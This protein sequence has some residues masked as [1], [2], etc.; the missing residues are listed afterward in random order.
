VFSFHYLND[1]P[2]ISAQDHPDLE[3]NVNG[4][5]LIAAPGWLANPPG[6]YLSL[7]TRVG[8]SGSRRATISPGHG[9]S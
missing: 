3:G 2:I 1:A 6:K 4:P 5:S 8:L 9:N 7:I